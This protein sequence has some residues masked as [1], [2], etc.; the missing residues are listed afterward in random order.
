[1]IDRE[2]FF[3]IRDMRARGMSIKQIAEAMDVDRK[4]VSKWIKSKELPQYKRKAPP[5]GKLEDHKKYVLSR[6]AEG[7]LNATVILE[8]IAER[9]YTGKITLLR[10]FM[11]PH[12]KTHSS[13]A[14]IRYETPPGKQAQVDWGSSRCVCQMAKRRS[15][16]PLSCCWVTP[17]SCTWSSQRTKRLKRL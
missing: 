1:M 8:E 2:G 9:G 11:K 16:M 12:R 4:T 7:C 13:S 3:M 6:M 14:S 5:K 10:D 17:D 15:C